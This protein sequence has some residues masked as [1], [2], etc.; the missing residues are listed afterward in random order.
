MAAVYAYVFSL[1]G[2]YI[3]RVTAKN[4]GGLVFLQHNR[5]IF[6]EDLQRVGIPNLQGA[7]Q[8]NGQDKAPHAVNAAD[9]T[10]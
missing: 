6:D 8:L 1:V 4:A 10:G 9:D 7:A 3:P 5:V 2:A